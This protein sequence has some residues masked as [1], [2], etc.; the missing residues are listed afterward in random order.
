MDLF[1]FRVVSLFNSRESNILGLTIFSIPV[2]EARASLYYL[3][4]L[5]R[6][7]AEQASCAREMCDLPTY[8]A[9]LALLALRT[10]KI[11]QDTFVLGQEK[12]DE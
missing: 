1:A 6:N 2:L 12:A 11:E 7:L 10:R 8:R 5:R 3:S 9:L 4:I